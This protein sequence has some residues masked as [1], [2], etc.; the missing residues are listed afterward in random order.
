MARGWHKCIGIRG[1]GTALPGNAV[2]IGPVGRGCCCPCPSLRW[3]RRGCA[4]LRPLQ[5]EW[6]LESWP[7]GSCTSSVPL[8]LQDSSLLCSVAQPAGHGPGVCGERQGGCC[9]S[10]RPLWRQGAVA[11]VACGLSS[12]GGGERGWVATWTVGVGQGKGRQEVPPA[13]YCPAGWPRHWPGTPGELGGGPASAEG[14]G[15]MPGTRQLGAG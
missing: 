8:T 15:S 10:R 9:W 6:G 12:A 13:Q 2:W 4:F 3:G 7:P 5:G 14:P 1:D 11:Q